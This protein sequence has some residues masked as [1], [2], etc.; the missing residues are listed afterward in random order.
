MAEQ[1]QQATWKKVLAWATIILGL[2]F[3]LGGAFGTNGD[4][5][6]FQSALAGILF[7]GAFIL[8]GAWWL[9]CEKRDRAA[10][11]QAAQH[12]ANY[13]LLTETD[14][15]MLGEPPAAEKVK[16]HWP[17]VAIA[18]VVALFI[19]AALTPGTETSANPKTPADTSV[20]VQTSVVKITSEEVVTV[21]ET[22]T[23]EAEP[24][25]TPEEA[26][27]EEPARQEKEASAAEEQPDPA[28][29]YTPEPVQEVPAAVEA[30]VATYYSSC[31][32]AKRAGAAPL[33]A[34]N[35]GYSSRLDRDGDGV[36]CER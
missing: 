20:E 15:V 6:R 16:R 36:A 11:A 18:S 27:I 10:H 25:V 30:P 32:E 3:M 19:G 5:D 29:V 21:T 35:P 7:G 34:G 31:A 9:H 1:Y 26:A 33:Y 2:V 17:A 12:A 8:P 28:P 13:Q 24:E 14:R 23:E 4:E 22:A